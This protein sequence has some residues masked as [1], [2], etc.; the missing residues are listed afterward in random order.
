MK[1]SI[2]PILDRNDIDYNFQQIKMALGKGLDSDNIRYEVIESTTSETPNSKKIFIH[3]LNAVP[4][5]YLP[6]YGN[7]YIKEVSNTGVD[8][9]S[10][11]ASTAFKILLVR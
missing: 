5:F 6:V 11:S 3:K 9:R 4:A 7:I 10:A 2:N 1:L 8:V